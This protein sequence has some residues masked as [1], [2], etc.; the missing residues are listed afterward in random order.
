MDKLLNCIFK[1]N[2]SACE[3]EEKSSNQINLDTINNS[4]KNDEEMMVKQT[5]DTAF[6]EVPHD[7]INLHFK[8]PIQTTIQALIDTGSSIQV[9]SGLMAMKFK[10]YLLNEKTSFKVR[11]GNGDVSC[12]QYLPVVIQHNHYTIK[13]KFYVMWDLPCDFLVGRSLLKALG[14]RIMKIDNDVFKHIGK[15][16][17]LDDDELDDEF[18]ERISYPLTNDSLINWD[19]ISI[20]KSADKSKFIKLLQDYETLIAR[21]E[22]DAGYLKDFEFKLEFLDEFKNAPP[23]V[24]SEYPLKR[25]V[26]AEVERQIQTMKENGVIAD[27][28]SQWNFLC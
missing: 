7:S 4:D 3:N 15:P 2:K 11:T 6:I 14:Y 8:L 23:I 18:F 9:I 22:V 5:I 26:V 24:C 20:G 17:M 10:P 12:R 16:D 28:T 25:S 13:T 19:G 27:S 21:H 1:L